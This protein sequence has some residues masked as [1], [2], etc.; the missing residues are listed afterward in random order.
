MSGTWTPGPEATT[1]ADTFVGGT[2]GDSANGLA[3]A[4]SLVGGA[5]ND[6]LLGG[7]DNDTIVGGDGSDFM[8]GGAGTGDIVS[9]DD[10]TTGVG[11]TIQGAA[12]I[13]TGGAAAGDTI[14]NFEGF[15][16]SDFDDTIISP[17]G[18]FAL[19][20]GAGNDLLL[21]GQQNDTI[22]GGSGIDTIFGGN[23][24]DSLTGGFFNPGSG[25]F[26]DD[27]QTDYVLG[28][29][30]D[31]TAWAGQGDVLTGN[32]GAGDFAYLPTGY[33][34]SGEDSVLTY[35]LPDGGT[36]T[37]SF[38]VWTSTVEGSQPI[39][40]NGFESTGSYEPVPCFATGTLVATAR[41][42]VA[43]EKLRVGDLV[44]TAHGG[45]YLQPVVWIGH[46][47]VMVAKQRNVA[48]AA[49]ILIKA[50][51]LADGV[52]HRDLRV[53]PEH[54]MFLD[55]RLVPAKLLVNGTSIIQELWCPEVTYW[56]VELPAHGL[57]VAEGAVSESYFD[58][59]NRKHF[60]N[61]GI[62]TL[63]KDF[64]SE[65]GN[66]RYAQAACYPL[67][68]EGA[69]LDRIRARLADR[70]AQRIADRQTA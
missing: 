56:H 17:N 34:D 4:D 43:V 61:F 51:A 50:G 35:P 47:K 27:S 58:D 49:P 38:D 5:G 64:E 20:G 30:G 44:V 48:T 68:A 25:T 22:I 16:G 15:I 28:G 33:I 12:N 23:S 40:L 6:T 31:D 29:Q 32:Q 39:Y 42:E 65:R 9:Y 57:L 53:S 24:G 19:Y 55:G 26:G 37:L 11:I 67:L 7:E 66:G 41:G 60:D 70:A 1:G 69:P 52:P 21:S 45:A 13:S 59:G 18:G 2:G 14:Q 62:T 8:D 10:A 54:A 46:S 3:G 63:F 36:D